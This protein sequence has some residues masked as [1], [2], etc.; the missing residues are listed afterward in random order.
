MAAQRQSCAGL[1]HEFQKGSEEIQNPS[2][3]LEAC[4]DLHWAIVKL[5][6]AGISWVE[7]EL[8]YLSVGTVLLSYLFLFLN[9]TTTNNNK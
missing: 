4:L 3:T 9:T 6:F 1:L 7:F 2:I 8:S 5:P